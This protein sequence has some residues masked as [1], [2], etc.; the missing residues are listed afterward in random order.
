MLAVS[1]GFL[2]EMVVITQWFLI[3]L[4][5]SA[6]ALSSPLALSS[7][8][9]TM[10]SNLGPGVGFGR[11][12]GTAN[13]PSENNIM[14]GQA[15]RTGSEPAGYRLNSVTL[16]LG[17]VTGDG[18]G[19]F[20]LE[21]YGQNKFNQS[22]VLIGEFIVPTNPTVAGLYSFDFADNG[23]KLGR[24]TQYVIVASSPN[25]T[26]PTTSQYG[27]RQNVS[28]TLVVE[29]GWQFGGP[30]TSSNGTTWAPIRA[31]SF[32]FAIDA[33]AIPEPTAATLLAAGAI[34]MGIKR[35]RRR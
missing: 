12:V 19:D 23:T 27:W 7:R 20:V 24:L 2:I 5:L 16:H 29:P 33:T 30:F 13:P 17:G 21:L 35:I 34:L 1:Y 9:E 25:S 28:S 14:L 31:N 10:L 4:N 32:Q 22:N 11:G 15:F 8:A 26:G 3:L 18:L 6:V